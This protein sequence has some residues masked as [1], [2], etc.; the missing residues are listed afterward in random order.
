MNTHLAVNY[1]LEAP[2]KFV[3]WL[4]AF[5]LKQPCWHGSPW[6]LFLVRVYHHPKGTT[7]FKMGVDFQDIYIYTHVR[8]CVLYP[9]HSLTTTGGCNGISSVS[10]N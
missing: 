1:D 8:V 6:P 4:D 3:V 2:P 5:S 7:I 10:Y 9:L